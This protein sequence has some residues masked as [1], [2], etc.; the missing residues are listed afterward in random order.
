MALAV[1]HRGTGALMLATGLVLTLR[2]YRIL[3]TKPV[4]GRE[5]PS[6]QVAA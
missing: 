2:V 4:V 6:A 5:F 3:R 1:S